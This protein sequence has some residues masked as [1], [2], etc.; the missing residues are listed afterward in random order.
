MEG[1]DCV[2]TNGVHVR[3]ALVARRPYC[4]PARDYQSEGGMVFKGVWSIR[5]GVT[6]WLNTSATLHL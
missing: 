2:A 6:E 3:C 1:R 4:C 5:G